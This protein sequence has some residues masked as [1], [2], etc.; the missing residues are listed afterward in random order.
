MSASSGG[1]MMAAVA[2]THYAGFWIRLLALVADVAIVV[3]ATLV[4]LF[5]SA[6]FGKTGLRIGSIAALV[7]QTLYWPLLHASEG[8]ASYGK[9]MLGLKVTDLEGDRISFVRSCGR[10]LAWI[11]S[12]LPVLLGF[13]MAAFTSRKQALHDYVASTCVVRDGPAH[14]AGAITVA[15]VGIV[16]PMIAIP[17]FF[18][19][20]FIGIVASVFGDFLGDMR[21]LAPRPQIQ[22]AARQ[23]PPAKS[24]GAVPTPAPSASAP[25]APPLTGSPEI[26]FDRLIGAPLTGFDQGGMTRAGPAILELSTMFTDTLWLKVHLPMPVAAEA[27]LVPGPR[28]SVDRVLDQAGNDFHDAG[29]TFET[30]E[31]FQRAAMS[32]ASIPVPHLMG[33]RSVHL[34]RGLTEQTLQKAEGQISITLPVDPR[35]VAFDA[36]ETGKEKT[37][38][39]S[40]LTLVSMSGD[41]VRMRFRGASE[42]LLRV[43]AFGADGQPLAPGSREILP[44]SQDVDQE[45]SASFKGAPARV[46][47]LVAARIIERTYP[48]AVMRGV[49]AG[50][51]SSATAGQTVPARPRAAR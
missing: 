51:P 45:F 46:E 30:K 21:R 35:T 17:M 19:A 20:M 37:A 31:F 3:V 23:T 33:I 18:M 32:P 29:S 43:R 10:A 42:H 34:R 13:A 11:V 28:V 44:E 7:L 48:F 47:A 15:V 16:G 40:A 26:D 14:V 27:Q 22:V 41:A 1:G 49:G 39:D 36:T 5:V 4:I 50:A 38:H 12:A 9:A 6:F 2:N 8:Q 25:A 24:P